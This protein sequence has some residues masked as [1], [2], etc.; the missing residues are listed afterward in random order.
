MKRKEEFP[1]SIALVPGDRFTRTFSR[2]HGFYRSGFS[3]GSLVSRNFG[4]YDLSSFSCEN[5]N[6]SRVSVYR[7]FRFPLISFFSLFAI[8]KNRER[9]RFPDPGSAD[10]GREGGSL[11][12][13][14]ERIALAHSHQVANRSSKPRL[15][16]SVC[17]FVRS[18]ERSIDQSID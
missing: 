1:I 10:L 12:G 7:E 9:A 3:Y 14:I 15:C 11:R 5:R 2:I 17:S 18:F 6:V 13:S 4:P 16:L 8:L